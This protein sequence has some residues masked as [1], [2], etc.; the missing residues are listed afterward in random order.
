MKKMAHALIAL[1]LAV[2]MLAQDGTKFYRLDF[3]LK[4]L[5]ENHKVVSQKN[6]STFMS[7]DDR[8]KGALIRT[9]TKVPYQS[10]AGTNYNYL[11][12]GVNIDCQ[13]IQEL[14]GQ[15][16]V[17]VSADITS[18]PAPS[19]VGTSGNPAESAV[20]GMPLVRQNRWNSVAVVAIG[21][22]TTLFSSDDLNTKRKLQLE[23]T[24]TPIK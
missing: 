2:P 6:Y 18:V 1:S 13:K 24:A 23:L 19:G 21:K 5:D 8:V 17:Q 16:V 3:A 20:P 10:S 22:A 9:G 14:N 11:D 7:T 15:L 12:V 4:E